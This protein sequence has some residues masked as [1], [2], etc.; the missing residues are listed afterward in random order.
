MVFVVFGGFDK[1]RFWRDLC[2]YSIL[3]GVLDTQEVTG[4]SPVPPISQTIVIKRFGTNHF[5]VVLLEKCCAAFLEA[6]L[7]LHRGFTART[8]IIR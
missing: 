8:M 6:L 7:Y 2:D 3:P 5:C 4:S 1:C